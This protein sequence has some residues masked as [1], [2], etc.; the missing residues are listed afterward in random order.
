M[1]HPPR[2]AA[3]D[4]ICCDG[5]SVR[6]AVG[7]SPRFVHC[8]RSVSFAQRHTFSSSVIVN[9]QF[10]APCGW[11]GNRTEAGCGDDVLPPQ[12]IPHQFASVALLRYS[13]FATSDRELLD[14]RPGTL[15][16]FLIRIYLLKRMNLAHDRIRIEQENGLPAV[17]SVRF[18]IVQYGASPEEMSKVDIQVPR[19]TQQ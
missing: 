8:P 7:S 9:K 10:D 5:I 12:C 19:P 13:Y 11:D 16:I 3:R 1:R 18:E 6:L 4:M 15:R 17:A 14:I 2:S